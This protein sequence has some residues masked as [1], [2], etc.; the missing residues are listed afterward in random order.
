M[1]HAVPLDWNFSAEGLLHFVPAGRQYFAY[2]VRVNSFDWQ[3]FYERLG[4]GVLLETV[5]QNLRTHYDVILIDSRTGV[6][7]T[8]GVCTIQMP[9]ELVVCFT[10]N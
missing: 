3:N 8:S 4:G 9:D 7:D 6:S 1:T 10:L 5:K 2:P